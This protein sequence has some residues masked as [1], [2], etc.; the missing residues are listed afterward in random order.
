MTSFLA[1]V[2]CILLL[3]SGV[4]LC[5]YLFFWLSNMAPGLLKYYKMRKYNLYC[6]DCK[7]CREGLVMSWCQTETKFD[8][9]TGEYKV[10]ERDCNNQYGCINCT[11]YPKNKK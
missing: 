3:V 9:V 10:E 8:P 11:F 7:H 2:L 5:V 6:K 4:F 1:Y